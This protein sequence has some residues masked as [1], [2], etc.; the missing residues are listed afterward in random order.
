MTEV[1][2]VLVLGTGDLAQKIK[3]LFAKAGMPALLAGEPGAAVTPDLVIEALPGTAKEKREALLKSAAASPQAILAT[4]VPGGVT[5][6]A[7]GTGREANTVGLYFMFNPFEEKCLVQ[8]VRGL[9]TAAEAVETCRKAVDTTGAATYEGRRLDEPSHPR[10]LQLSPDTTARLFELAARLGYFHSIALE[11]RQAVANLGLKTF[12]YEKD[13]ATNQV[14][15]NYTLR[16][17]ANELVNWFE[18]IGCVMQHQVALEYAM[19]YDHLGLPRELLQIKQDLAKKA[20]ADPEL[21]VPV[22]EQIAQDSRY[23]NV[24]KNRAQDIL[25]QLQAKR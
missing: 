7:A 21:L 12:R 13:G 8:I 15:F 23:L 25:R 9:E 6:V 16:Q 10:A 4:T 17:D 3:G 2:K 22:L 19:K 14:Q 18:R 5:E 24:A 11:S 1:S 20:L